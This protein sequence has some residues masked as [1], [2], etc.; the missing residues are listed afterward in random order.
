MSNR[1][2]VLPVRDAAAGPRPA[3]DIQ[4]E[5]DN[6]L[7]AERDRLAR[8]NAFKEERAVWEKSGSDITVERIRQ[9]DERER[10]FESEIESGQKVISLLLVQLH[11][12]RNVEWESKKKSRREELISR[13]A[14]IVARQKE[15]IGHLADAIKIASELWGY[16]SE[17]V[18]FN[19]TS[20]ERVGFVERSEYKFRPRVIRHT[21][22]ELR[23]VARAFGLTFE[24][25]K[26]LPSEEPPPKPPAAPAAAPAPQEASG[27]QQPKFV[28][29]PRGL[30]EEP[31]VERPIN[32]VRTVVG[33][34]VRP[35]Q[36]T[37]PESE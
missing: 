16:D 35:D 13:G 12:V 25:P 37:E 29:M 20:N 31:Q 6:A 7:V 3:A 30:A 10:V 24:V 23:D 28:A 18:A 1:S 8:F 32:L 27:Y 19:Q 4:K 14:V 34:P 21:W 9:F 2:S 17:E 36:K 22:D 11:Q 5:I 33:R 15:C 26:N